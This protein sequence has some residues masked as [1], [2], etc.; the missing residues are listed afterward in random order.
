MK[1]F[2]S[3]GGSVGFVAA[4]LSALHAGGALGFA[5]RDGAI[6]CLAGAFLLRGFHYVFTFC[7]RSLIQEQANGTYPGDPANLPTNEAKGQ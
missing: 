6:G 3:L 1:F 2:L 5:L 7:L 4:F